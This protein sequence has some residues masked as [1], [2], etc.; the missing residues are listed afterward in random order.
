[1]ALPR[2]GFVK[3]RIDRVDNETRTLVYSVI[4][5]AQPPANIPEL[6]FTPTVDKK[7]KALEAPLDTQLS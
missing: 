6:T 4:M 1:M 3:Q 5:V 2:A 7:T